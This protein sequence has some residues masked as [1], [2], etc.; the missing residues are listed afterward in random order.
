MKK[1]LLSGGARMVAAGKR[2]ILLGPSNEE[3]EIL[4]KAAENENRAVTQYV[5]YHALTAAK[6]NISRKSNK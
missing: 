6:K 5:L 4:K 1:K 3:W 2:P